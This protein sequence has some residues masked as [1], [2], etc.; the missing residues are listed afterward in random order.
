MIR[1]SFLLSDSIGFLN[2]SRCR[3]DTFMDVKRHHNVS[4][5]LALSFNIIFFVLLCDETMS[6]RMVEGTFLPATGE[7]KA[8]ET[9]SLS[10]SLR[11]DERLLIWRQR[12]NQDQQPTV[13]QRT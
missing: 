2:V 6:N 12:R 13:Q 1:F 10:L 7:A 11:R 9:P 3:Q 5:A 4:L 8:K